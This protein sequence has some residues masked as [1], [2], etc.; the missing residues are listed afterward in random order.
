MKHSCT[1]RVEINP[2]IKV[3][4][5]VFLIDGSGLTLVKEDDSEDANEYYIIFSYPDKTGSKLLLQ[6]I[7]AKV[8]EVNVRDKISHR[9]D[10]L[11]NPLL[12]DIVVKVGDAEFRTCSKLV[13]KVKDQTYNTIYD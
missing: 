10:T 9:V 7:E 8:I 13:K 1:I 3:G 4:D 6:S 11:M 2:N 12:Q 5:K